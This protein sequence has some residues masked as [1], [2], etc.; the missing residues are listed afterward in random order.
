MEKN[1]PECI[2]KNKLVLNSSV[3]EWNGYDRTLGKNL[4]GEK[5]LIQDKI[6]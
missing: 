2:V 1:S 5:F 6:Q 3:L 4:K